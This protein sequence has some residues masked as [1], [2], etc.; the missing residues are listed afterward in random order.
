MG[1]SAVIFACGT[2][3]LGL[4]TAFIGKVGDDLFGNFMIDSMKECGIDVTGIRLSKEFKTGFS[5]ILSR[6]IDRAILT[7]SGSIPELSFDDID[8]KLVS[9]CAHLHLSSYFLLDKLRPD[10]PKLFSHA[11]ETGLTVSLDTNY[12]PREKWDGGLK[13]ALRFVDVFLPNETEAFGISGKESIE[14]AINYLGKQMPT[15]V[16]KQ[17]TEG[18]IAKW[19]DSSMLKQNA[20]PV[21]V[22]DTVGAGDSFDAGFIYG[23]VKGLDHLKTMQIAVA[24]GSIS[25]QQ[26]GGTQGQS[27]LEMAEDL[28]RKNEK[29]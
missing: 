18:A 20:F 23:F 26:A 24:C 28:I 9:Q 8:L 2:A 3:R 17:G 10:V 1:S 15:V 13:D 27:T 21:K 12:D 6:K 16:I 11:R 14:E 4:K 5:V 29:I 25:T 22:V 19:K 7:F